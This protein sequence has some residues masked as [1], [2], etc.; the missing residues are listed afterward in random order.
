MKIITILL[1][2]LTLNSA[3]AY[4]AKTIL[5]TANQK[6]SLEQMV[7]QS[8]GQRYSVQQVNV[9]CLP[10][11]NSKYA[12]LSS[13]C[14]TKAYRDLIEIKNVLFLIE[15]SELELLAVKEGQKLSFP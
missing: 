15:G 5:L 13:L 6:S 9:R 4:E 14:V 1:T 8:T 2:L 3:F 12:R 7:A 10:Y 11:H